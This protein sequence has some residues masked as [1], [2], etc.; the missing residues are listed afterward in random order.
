[1]SL[2]W[3]GA[4][5]G[6]A[7]RGSRTHNPSSK[8]KKAAEVTTRKGQQA[9]P[10]TGHRIMEEKKRSSIFG[11]YN[12]E[13]KPDGRGGRKLAKPFVDRGK[14][15]PR[16]RK[17]GGVRKEK[18]PLDTKASSRTSRKTENGRGRWTRKF[19]RFRGKRRDDQSV[20]KKKSPLRDQKRAASRRG[21]GGIAAWGE[22]HDVA[23]TKETLRRPEP[24]TRSSGEGRRDFDDSVEVNF[25]EPRHQ[26][27]VTGAFRIARTISAKA[28]AREKRTPRAKE[29]R[30]VLRILSSKE[31][32]TVP[33]RTFALGKNQSL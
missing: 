23:A 26:D 20:R 29:E 32:P 21:E 13:K 19:S 24:T 17:H 4:C 2:V 25:F 31:K 11:Y 3:G 33:K 10:W 16:R 18:D 28:N 9:K 7:A 30:N 27:F 8:T 1:V 15:H 12:D 22:G 5:A 6:G 14:A